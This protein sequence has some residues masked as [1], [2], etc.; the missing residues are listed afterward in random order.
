MAWLE[1]VGLSRQQVAKVVAG[2]P[3][4]LGYSIEC[5]LKPTVAWLEDV[6]LSRQQVAKVVARFPSV[7][8]Y[9]IDNNLSRKYFLLRQFFS[10]EDICSMIACLPQMLGLSY[11]RLF[12]RVQVLQDYDCLYKLARVM[13]LTNAKFDRRFP[14]GIAAISL[15]VAQGKRGPCRFP[16]LDI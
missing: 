3:Q 7:L 6:G 15:G 9:S 1:D 10:K 11:A 13:A 16:E 12:H 14:S 8:G 5:N 4:V 2:F